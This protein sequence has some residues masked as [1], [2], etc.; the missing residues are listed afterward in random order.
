MEERILEVN[1][2]EGQGDLTQGQHIN[3][4]GGAARNKGFE[5]SRQLMS[6]DFFF[7]RVHNK[8]IV[9]FLKNLPEK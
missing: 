5:K 7:T 9:S 6:I 3:L 8:S 2:G 1:S 4:G